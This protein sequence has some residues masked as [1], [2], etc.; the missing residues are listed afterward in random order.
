MYIIPN[1]MVILPYQIKI[2]LVFK[3][4]Q[5]ETLQTVAKQEYLWWEV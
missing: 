4:K 3:T 1:Q 2:I 5:K